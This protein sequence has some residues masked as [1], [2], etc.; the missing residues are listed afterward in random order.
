MPVIPRQRR[1]IGAGAGVDFLEQPKRD[2]IHETSELLEV[3]EGNKYVS[4]GMLLQEFGGKLH[5]FSELY[6]VNKIT[7]H[8]DRRGGGPV[9]LGGGVVVVKDGSSLP[10]N[11]P[12]VER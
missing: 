2:R 1:P 11:R 8:R 5:G 3:A 9:S 10:K 6:L 4:I 12:K 7:K